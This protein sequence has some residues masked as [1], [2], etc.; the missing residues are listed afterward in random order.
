MRLDLR[1]DMRGNRPTFKAMQQILHDRQPPT[2]VAAR[3]NDEIFP[4]E[5]QPQILTGRVLASGFR[6]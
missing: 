5:V 2:P 4:G 3:V 6:S 1:C